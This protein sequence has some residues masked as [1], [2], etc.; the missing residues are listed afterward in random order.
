[1]LRHWVSLAV[2]RWG[3]GGA[4]APPIFDRSVNPISTGGADYAHHSTTSLPPKFSDL[5]TGLDYVDGKI[6]RI[7]LLVKKHYIIV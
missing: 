1:M 3:L 4:S 2:A 5:A 7:L 6:K